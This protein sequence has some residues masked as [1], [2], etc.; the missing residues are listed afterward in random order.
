MNLGDATELKERE[1]NSREREPPP[2]KKK[3]RRAKKGLRTGMWEQARELGDK[4][5]ACR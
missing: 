4:G 5:S 2:Q 1:D 3:I